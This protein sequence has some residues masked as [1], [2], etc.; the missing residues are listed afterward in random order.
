MVSMQGACLSIES[1]WSTVTQLYGVVP[2]NKMLH[3]HTKAI[4]CMLE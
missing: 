1:N 3:I 4:I 2:K